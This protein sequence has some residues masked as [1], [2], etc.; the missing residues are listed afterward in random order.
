MNIFFVY[1]GHYISLFWNIIPYIIPADLTWL[2]ILIFNVCMPNAA[3]MTLCC[4]STDMM[5]RFCVFDFT[6]I[7]ST[8]TTTLL[9]LKCPI[10]WENVWNAHVVMKFFIISFI[11]WSN[12]LKYWPRFNTLLLFLL[13][14]NLRARTQLVFAQKS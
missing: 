12:I 5:F 2:P 14:F 3:D 13:Q 4:F 9:G 1:F 11:S 8:T 10:P 7:T 6:E